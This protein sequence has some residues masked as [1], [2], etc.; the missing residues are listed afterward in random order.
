MPN[1]C[2]P[3]PLDVQTAQAGAH[4]TSL[5]PSLLNR[6]KKQNKRN[7]QNTTQTASSSRAR[8]ADCRPQTTETAMLPR[9][10]FAY[11]QLP[12]VCFV[13]PVLL[14]TW[15]RGECCLAGITWSTMPQHTLERSTVPQGFRHASLYLV[16]IF[17]ARNVARSEVEVWLAR[18]RIPAATSFYIQ[19]K[20][21]LSK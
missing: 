2:L 3:S 13:L 12:C 4:W 16:R 7:R 19:L 9:I 1:S 10:S 8:R 5:L 21:V 14:R 17:S 6:K 15:K 11:A 20:N 18:L